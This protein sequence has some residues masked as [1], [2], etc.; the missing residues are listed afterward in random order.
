MA[1]DVANGQCPIELE[2]SLARDGR[3]KKLGYLYGLKWCSCF[4]GSQRQLSLAV[5]VEFPCQHLEHGWIH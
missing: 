5:S 1:P 3:I 4:E 2:G